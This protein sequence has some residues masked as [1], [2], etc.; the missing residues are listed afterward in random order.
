[1]RPIGATLEDVF[2]AMLT[3]SGAGGAD[4]GKGQS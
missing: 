1:V 3:R 4:T 2:I